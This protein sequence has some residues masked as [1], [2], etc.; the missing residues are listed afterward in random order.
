[1]PS[2][3]NVVKEITRSERI[4]LKNW[5]TRELRMNRAEYEDCGEIN[6]TKL[7]EECA[8]ILDRDYLLDA[9]GVDGI[10]GLAAEV[11]ERFERESND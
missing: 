8:L 9:E 10:W 3:A 5:M 4:L 6:C 1:M 2:S 7:A 11:T